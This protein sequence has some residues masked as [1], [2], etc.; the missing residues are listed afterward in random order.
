MSRAFSLVELSIVLVILGLLVGGI[1]AGKSLIRSSEIRKHVS[2]MD[3]FQTAYNGFKGRY[4]QMPGDI[5]I[6]T[7]IWST[8]VCGVEGACNGNGDGYI[9]NATES[10]QVW[11]Q[12]ERAGLWP[13]H[14]RGT[15]R[16]TGVTANYDVPASPIGNNLGV[17]F[18]RKI[19]GLGSVSHN[20][21]PTGHY[22]HVGGIP[23]DSVGN[24]Y[25]QDNA[26]LPTEVWQID[27]KM[28]DGMP[29]NGK[30]QASEN[31]GNST[32]YYLSGNGLPCA[33]WTRMDN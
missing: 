21:I 19:L 28:D 5:T 8:P 3:K 20:F 15:Y 2:E 23:D 32:G 4:F 18:V 1:L 27:T 30:V 7:S 11:L 25:M 24:G 10:R 16:T 13:G 33:F 22:L 26:V 14:Y 17:D 9:G 29:R 31:C 12:L 6:A